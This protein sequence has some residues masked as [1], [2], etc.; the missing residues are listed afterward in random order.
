MENLL[1]TLPANTKLVGDRLERCAVVN[2]ELRW[3]GHVLM[4]P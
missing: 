2:V 3:T 4:M 1:D